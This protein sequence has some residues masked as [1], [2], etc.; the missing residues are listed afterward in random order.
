MPLQMNIEDHGNDYYKNK[1]TF[2]RLSQRI[3]QSK[4]LSFTKTSIKSEL[5]VFE[6]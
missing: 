6:P 3:I 1:N 4:K 2:K 5:H